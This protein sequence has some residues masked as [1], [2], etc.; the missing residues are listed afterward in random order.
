VL[1]ET[2]GHPWTKKALRKR[3]RCR[4]RERRGFFPQRF[5]PTHYQWFVGLEVCLGEQ[6]YPNKVRGVG[7]EGGGRPVHR[8]TH[9]MRR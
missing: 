5:R 1:A 7:E 2:E 9:Y 3:H 4:S 6:A 8:T